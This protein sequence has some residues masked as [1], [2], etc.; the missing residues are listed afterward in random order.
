MSGTLDHLAERVDA[1]PGFLGHWLRLWIDGTGG[2]WAALCGRIGLPADE[3]SRLRLCGLPRP[4]SRGI[5][6]EA[7]ATR[8]GCDQA[9]LDALLAELG[10]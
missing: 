7:I 6:L 1:D 10:V 4:H 9:G 5:E 8:F 2:T 3:L